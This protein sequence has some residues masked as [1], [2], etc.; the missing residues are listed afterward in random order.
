M[1]GRSVGEL[2]GVALIVRQIEREGPGALFA[3][4]GVDRVIEEIHLRDALL[5]ID[6]QLNVTMLFGGAH[7]TAEDGGVNVILLRRKW[8][9]I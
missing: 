3:I 9:W 2:E 1:I 6:V 5:S 7:M 8:E 4:N